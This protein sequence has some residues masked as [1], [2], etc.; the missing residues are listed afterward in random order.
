LNIFDFG[1][2]SSIPPPKKPKNNA[3]PIPLEARIASILNVGMVTISF[4]KDI[5]VVKNL[6]AF[7][8]S[9]LNIKVE[10][11]PDSTPDNLGI[12]SWNVTFMS[13]RQI[14]IKLVFQNPLRISS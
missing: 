6:T 11:G 9:V 4:N 7:Q 3:K 2:K 10:P 13:S 8:D 12:T 5:L 1:G 14:K